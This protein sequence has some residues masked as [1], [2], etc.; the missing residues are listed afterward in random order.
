[1]DFGDDQGGVGDVEGSGYNREHSWPQSWFGGSVL[2]MRSDLFQLYPTDAHVNNRR[3]SFPYGEVDSPTWT[4]LNGSRV[5][6]CS[7]PGYSGTV[8]E[9]IDE[10]KGDFARSYFY[11]TVR[12]YGED[13]SWP[14]SDMTDGAE[15]L[16]WAVNLLLDWHDQDPVS[17]KE[18][19]RNGAVYAIQ[20]NRN[21][22]IDRPEFAEWML[23]PALD[24]VT[25][26]TDDAFRLDQ[27]R[28]NPFRDG[29]VIVLSL[30]A[31]G[32]VDLSVFDVS[33]RLVT[34]LLDGPLEAGLH[35]VR[36]SGRNRSGQSVAPGVYFYRIDTGDRRETRRM[37]RLR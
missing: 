35:Q 20:A 23:S 36:W 33:G 21:P 27:N 2:P 14:G 1:Y 32:A 31:A 13:G 11:M 9:P 29:T 30:P 7:Y 28:P 25:L 34:R 22:F 19:D 15:L 3:G 10:Y 24:A 26:G 16:P 17:Q 37:V 5:G 6:P 12:Y 4:S 8:F 18:I